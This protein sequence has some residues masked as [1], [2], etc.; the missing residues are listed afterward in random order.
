MKFVPKKLE[1][2]ADVSRGRVTWSDNL[3]SALCVV[4]VLLFLYLLLGVVAEVLA[5]RIP[6][7]WETRLFS[8]DIG[9]DPAESA[10]LERAE[11]IFD[12]LVEAAALRPLPYDL[13]HLDIDAPNA[14]AVPG[15]GVGVTR[16]LLERVDGEMGLAMVLAHE[17]GH[18]QHRHALR[19]LGRTLLVRGAMALLFGDGG[20]AVVESS[21]NLVESSYS[22][23]QEREADAFGLRLVQEAYGHT[24]GCL[25]FF[26]MIEKEFETDFSRWG[27]LFA[28]HP[29]TRER[30]EDLKGLQR[31]LSLPAQR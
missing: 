10:E 16:G 5:T 21:V 15:G 14:M 27:S 11:K 28:S 24:E 2:T 19:R 31:A 1:N 22:R 8:W 18:H 6:E 25:E 23:D 30:I 7:S 29:L 3:K 20:V 17:L 13:F 9:D 12:R 26:Q 4:I